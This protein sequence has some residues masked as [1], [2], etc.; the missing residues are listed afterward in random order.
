MTQGPKRDH[1]TSPVGHAQA[2]HSRCN[3]AATAEKAD[4]GGCGESPAVVPWLD[5]TMNT[6]GEYDGLYHG[7]YDGYYDGNYDGHYDGYYDGS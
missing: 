2:L 4:L 6:D 1:G 5:L 3:W 7:Y